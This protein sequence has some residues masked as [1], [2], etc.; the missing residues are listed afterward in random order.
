VKYYGHIENKFIPN[1]LSKQD[2]MIAP[3]RWETLPF[4]ILEAQAM[5]VPVVAFNIPGPSD[6]IKNKVTGFLVDNDSLFLD[7]IKEVVE[8]KVIFN[9]SAIIQ[10]IKGKFNPEEKYSEMINLF[11]NYL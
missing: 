4:S 5:G 2:L 11:K 10:N 9:R 1:I 3:S 7:K 6:I 8:E